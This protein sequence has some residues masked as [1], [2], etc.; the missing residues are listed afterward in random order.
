VDQA[1]R[2]LSEAMK[3]SGE[4]E[5]TPKAD[6]RD[7]DEQLDCAICYEPLAAKGGAVPLPCECRIV[8]CHHCW[9]RALAASFSACGSALCPSC[10]SPLCVELDARKGRLVF[11][12]IPRCSGAED[13]VSDWRLRV[14]AQAKPVQIRLLEEFGAEVAA[15]LAATH[16]AEGEPRSGGSMPSTEAASCPEPNSRG[17]GNAASASALSPRAD[18]APVPRCVCGWRLKC[19]STR[20]RVLD[21]MSEQPLPTPPGL[22]EQVLRR[23]PIVCDICQRQ[24]GPK[25]N[26]W[27]CENGRRT[28]LHAVAYDVCHTCFQFHAYGIEAGSELDEEED[29][30]SDENAMDSEDELCNG[31][32]DSSEDSGW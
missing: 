28:V 6:G 20:Q 29:A 18:S 5:G 27:T 8:Y 14:Y 32:S 4:C 17:S 23:P 1:S 25:G 31:S 12:K 26:V 16:T 7:D 19:T 15:T 30:T 2:W 11:K 13:S 24:L 22:V 10:R 3:A 21:F 9:D